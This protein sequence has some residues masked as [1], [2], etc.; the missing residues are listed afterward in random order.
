MPSAGDDGAQKKIVAIYFLNNRSNASRAS[1]AFRG[2]GVLR[3]VTGGLELP[4]CPL[5]T[6][7]ATV[8]RGENDAH[9]LG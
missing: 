5:T 8:T 4:F 1:L 3:L 9:S 7:R 6:S 2:G